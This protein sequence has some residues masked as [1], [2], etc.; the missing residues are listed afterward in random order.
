[1]VVHFSLIFLLASL[2]FSR[3]CLSCPTHGT[4]SCGVFAVHKHGV[5]Y[6]AHSV[7]YI[8]LFFHSVI[9]ASTCILMLSLPVIGTVPVGLPA[10][11]PTGTPLSLTSCTHR[12]YLLCR[13]GGFLFQ[14]EDVQA[15][16]IYPGNFTELAD[17]LLSCGELI[18]SILR[19]LAFS[20]ALVWFFCLGLFEDGITG[21]CH[22]P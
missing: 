22:Y 16:G 19:L 9:M 3:P 2:G 12:C 17:A 10:R 15:M 13:V 5:T 7:V 1:M 14:Q 21:L 8:F 6:Q 20:Q 11:S 18:S 4:V